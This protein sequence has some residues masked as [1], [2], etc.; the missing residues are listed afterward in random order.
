[1]TKLWLKSSVAAI[2][3]TVRP[4]HD[5]SSIIYCAPPETVTYY[6]VVTDG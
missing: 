3:K 1:M 6:S 2:I 4:E 5:S